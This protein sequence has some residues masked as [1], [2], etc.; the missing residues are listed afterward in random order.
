MIIMMYL[1]HSL[2]VGTRQ[3]DGGGGGGWSRTVQG[4]AGAED[5][6]PEEDI[7]QVDE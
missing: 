2:F 4:A 6:C 7:H 3:H 1:T 5:V